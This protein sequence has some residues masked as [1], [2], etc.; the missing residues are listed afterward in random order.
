M[1]RDAKINAKEPMKGN[2][3]SQLVVVS[4]SQ[5]RIRASQEE[6]QNWSQMSEAQLK[7]ARNYRRLTQSDISDDIVQR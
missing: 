5:D 6:N 2:D 7:K 3:Q 1:I 4:L